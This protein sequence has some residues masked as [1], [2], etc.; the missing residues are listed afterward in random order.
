MGK[1]SLMSEENKALARR[2]FEELFNAHNLD[3]ADE[4]T[5]QDAVSHDLSS[6]PSRPAPKGI[7]TS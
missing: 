7:S 5:A 1:E 6:P 4:I 3:V 2:W